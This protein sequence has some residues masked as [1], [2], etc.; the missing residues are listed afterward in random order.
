MQKLKETAKKYKLQADESNYR[1]NTLHGMIQ[2][3]SRSSFRHGS[4]RDERIVVSLSVAEE[5]LSHLEALL[6][7]FTSSLEE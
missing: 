7:A 3:Q 2:S 5:C 6:G 4:I 1:I